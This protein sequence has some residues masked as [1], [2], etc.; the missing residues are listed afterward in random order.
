M[1]SSVSREFKLAVIGESMAE[2]SGQPFSMMQQGMGGDTMNTAIYLKMLCQEHG[3]VSYVTAMGQDA[4]S[5]A[6][7]AKWHQYRLDTSKVMINNDK[8]V[9]LY[10]IL[11][12]AS[13]ERTFQYWR[14][15]SA[16]R[17]M[18][19]HPEK[20]QI[21]QQLSHYDGVFLS[22][23][24]LAILPPQDRKALIAELHRLRQAGVNIFFDGNYRP[25]L[26]PSVQE[27]RASYEQLYRLSDVVLVT[28][29]DEQMLWG[30]D[31]INACQQ[32]L[33]AYDAPELIIKDGENGCLYQSPEHAFIVPTRP[34]NNVVDTTAAGDSFNAGF[35]AGWLTQQSAKRCCELGNQLAGQVIQKQGAI[36]D[37]DL[38]FCTAIATPRPKEHGKPTDHQ[39][40][41]Q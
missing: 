25:V 34:V 27:A 30:D 29:D 23:I 9:G 37:I 36:V 40:A 21:F 22:G 28:F 2:I 20:E 39:V 38:S 31:D 10:Y 41:C 17:Y 16:A 1:L 32:R 18:M 14:N 8:N 13:G 5:Q 4:L 35:L 19:Q 26:W 24:S 11:N 33:T 3:V 15:D 6:I 7:V 12:D